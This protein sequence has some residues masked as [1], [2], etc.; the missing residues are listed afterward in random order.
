MSKI[1]VLPV[2]PEFPDTFW[3][4][5]KTMKTIGKKAVMPPTGLA[6]ALAMLPE[7]KFEPQRIIDLNI[8][9][10]TDH[11]IKNADIIF[12]STMI[13]QEDSHNEVI[14]KAHFHGKPVVAGGPFPTSYPERNSTVDFIVAGEAEATLQ[15]FLEDL[16]NGAP[17]KIYTEKDVLRRRTIPLTKTG[18]V[19]TTYTPL[20]RWDLLNLNN[21]YSAAIQYSRGCPF[22]C[23][24]CDITKLFGKEPRTKTPEQMI[25]EFNA[26]Y[27]A[28]HRGPVF[29]VDDNL[30]GNRRNLREFL[31]YLIE[32]QRNRNYLFSLYTE[33]SMNLAWSENKDILEGMVEAGFDQVFLGIESIDPEVLK[34]MQKSQNTKMPQLEAVRRIQQAGLEVTGG[35]IIGSDGEKPD[36]FDNLFNF[37]QES[38][39]VV[40]MPGLL[41]VLNDTDLYKRL[42]KEGRL[43]GESRGNNT[44]QLSFNFKPQQ[45]E[46]FLIDGYKK[47][48]EKLFSPKNYYERGRDLQRNLGPHHSLTRTNLEGLTAFGRSLRKQ[49]FAKGGFEYARYLI[50]TFIKNPHYFPEAVAQAIKLDHFSTITRATLEADDYIPHADSLYEQFMKRVEDIYSRY[51]ENNDKRMR[52]I[53]EMAHNLIGKAEKQYERLH[54]DFRSGAKNALDNLKQ[55]VSS[56]VENYKHQGLNST[57]A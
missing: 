29:V 27:K 49:L 35:F 10:L 32:W 16:V 50:E 19:D 56:Y 48:L 5:K 34:T 7:E 55:R 46:T 13:V 30:I 52:L 3:G 44:H 21:Y 51:R 53:S 22:D 26:L 39:I 23:D 18:R 17:Q 42:E 4:Y 54:K 11:H 9:P 45:D 15:P 40:P 33:A 36:V 37:I 20:P 2:Y 47:L 43:R 12:T 8:E 57:L 38:G 41:Q 24:F 1:K 31:P 14:E 28:G 25:S 6:T